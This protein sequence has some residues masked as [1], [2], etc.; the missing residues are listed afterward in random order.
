MPLFGTVALLAWVPLP[1]GGQPDWAA[2]LA[3]CLV[4]ALLLGW[5]VVAPRRSLLPHV[6]AVLVLAALLVA[7]VSAWESCCR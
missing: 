5:C 7:G 1:I 4:A 2:S 3:A 6:P